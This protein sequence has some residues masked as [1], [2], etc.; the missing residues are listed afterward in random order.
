MMLRLDESVTGLFGQWNAYTSALAT[1]LI[2]IVSYQIFSRRDPDTHPLL[3]ARQ[4]QPSLVRQE[5]ESPV[6]RSHATPHGGPLN[7]GLNIH[8]PG[9]SKW[10]RGRDGDLRDIWRRA[11]NGA[12]EGE[13]PPGIGR[14]MTVYGRENVVEQSL[15]MR[16]SLVAIQ[17]RF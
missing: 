17:L 9:V 15:G 13:G 6:Y 14:V 8:D 4:S 1:V 7:G 11:V 16:P 3:L 10:S 12:P 5:G 2:G